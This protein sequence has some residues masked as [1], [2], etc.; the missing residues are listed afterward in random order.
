VS[1]DVFRLFFIPALTIKFL[2]RAS[3]QRDVLRW[4]ATV[5]ASG[6]HGT[7]QYALAERPTEVRQIIAGEAESAGANSDRSG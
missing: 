3:T 1:A 2:K 5:T 7:W 4:V 6:S